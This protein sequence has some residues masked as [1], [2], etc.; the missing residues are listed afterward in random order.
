MIIAH[1]RPGLRRTY[2]LHAFEPEKRQSLERWAMRL[3]EIVEAKPVP[4]NVVPLRAQPS[5]GY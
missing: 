3:R 5:G 2:D 4:N 1:A